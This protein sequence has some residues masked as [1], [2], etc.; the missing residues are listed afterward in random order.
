MVDGIDRD[1]RCAACGIG[2][3]S[4]AAHTGSDGGTRMKVVGPK[5]RTAL[6]RLPHHELSAHYHT[7]PGSTREAF[8][9]TAR[10]D[11]PRIGSVAVPDWADNTERCSMNEQRVYVVTEGKYAAYRIVAIFSE[12]TFAEKFI[13]EGG[14]DKFEEWILNDTDWQ[15]GQ[16]LYDFAFNLGGDIVKETLEARLSPTAEERQYGCHWDRPNVPTA[17]ADEDDQLVRIEV[18]CENRERAV[19]IASE[20]YNRIR[21]HLDHALHLAFDTPYPKICDRHTRNDAIQIAEIL[22]GL[23]EPPIGPEYTSGHAA[24]IRMALML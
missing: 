11:F 23:R 13:A 10:T 24:D 8:R 17:R 6:Y 19:E 20:R 5:L 7:G 3:R 14:G 1:S 21:T 9:A 12:R 16:G 15:S 2:G 22:A 4:E 18:Q